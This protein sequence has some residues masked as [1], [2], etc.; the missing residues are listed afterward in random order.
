MAAGDESARDDF[1]VTGLRVLITGSSRGLG[2]GIAEYLAR[3]GAAV[4]VHGRDPDRVEAVRERLASGGATVAAV[5]GEARD[6]EAVD[7]FVRGAADA[8]GGLDGV[9]SNAGGTFGAAAEDISPNGFAAVI[10]TNLNG[11]FL[12]ARA[13]LP[14]LEATGGSLIN[15]GSV[16]GLRP[17]PGFAHYGAAKAGLINLTRSL[18]A[19]WGARGV[20]VNA[21]LPGL[22]GTESSLESLFDNDPDRIRQAEDRIGVGRLGRPEDVAMACRYLLS[23]AAG[24]VNGEALVVDGG[25]PKVPG[26]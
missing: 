26:F 11:P 18:A 4:A 10:A 25:P 14:H 21:V 22:L 2:Q 17:S 23:P 7:A 5:R 19:E 1:D 6:A 13:V 20:R 12:V 9:I 8:L 24:F 3:C 16:S 15:I